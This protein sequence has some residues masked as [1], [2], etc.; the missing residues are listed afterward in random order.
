M[1]QAFQNKIGKEI[2]KLSSEFSLS[3]FELYEPARYMLSLGG[4]RLRP[5]F[6]LTAC[7]LFGGTIEDAVPAALAIELFHNFTL[8]HDDIMDNAPLRRNQ[9]TVHHKWNNNTAILSG[10]VILVKAYQL[11]SKSEL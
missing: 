3:P 10:D 4:K 9:P 8:V 2:E 6:V 7:D 5:V 1:I 11:L